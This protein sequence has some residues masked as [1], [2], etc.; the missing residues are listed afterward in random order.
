MNFPH[1]TA[2]IIVYLK[3][4]GMVD[5]FARIPA[6]PAGARR[7]FVRCVTAFLQNIFHGDTAC[8]CM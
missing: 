2:R 3:G 4:I 8:G 5:T 6:H 7:R 1:I